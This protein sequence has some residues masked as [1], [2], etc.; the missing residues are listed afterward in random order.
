VRVLLLMLS[1]G[2]QLLHPPYPSQLSIEVFL[3]RIPIQKILVYQFSQ[4]FPLPLDLSS[5]PIHPASLDSELIDFSFLLFLSLDF[6]SW[7]KQV[8]SSPLF[9][10]L[11]LIFSFLLP[12]FSLD[13]FFNNTKT[14]FFLM[15]ISISFHWDFSIFF[16][17]PAQTVRYV[18]LPHPFL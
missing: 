10:P 15:S 6:Y 8:F 2:F 7:D 9:Y 5:N 16:F 17:S 3:F 18:P 11:K 14:G 1:R 4:P 12:L 13:P